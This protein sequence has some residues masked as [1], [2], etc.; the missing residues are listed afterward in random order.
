V[1]DV[2]HGEAQALLQLRAARAH[3]LAQLRVRGW[4]AARPSGST[5]ACATSARPSA[6]ALLLAAG[7]LRGLAI[8][9]ER[10]PSRLRCLATRL[11]LGPPPCAPTGRR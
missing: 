10:Q 11:R 7:E 3:L 6:D 4:T 8:E 1:R 2:D 5:L 9:Q